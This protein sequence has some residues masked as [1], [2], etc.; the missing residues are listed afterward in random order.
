[1]FYLRKQKLNKLNRISLGAI[2]LLLVFVSTSGMNCIGGGNP[3][4][5]IV[6]DNK[7][8][9]QLAEDVEARIFVN[10]EMSKN[11]VVLKAGKWVL[12]DPGDNE[13]GKANK[14]D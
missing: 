14:K 11:K 3:R 13:D 8:P 10:G 2:G 12:S 7:T 5:I 1:M 9:V 4:V 6:D